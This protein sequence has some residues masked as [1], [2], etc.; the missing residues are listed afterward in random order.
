MKK[1][2]ENFLRKGIW[3]LHLFVPSLVHPYMTEVAFNLATVP[4]SLSMQWYTEVSQILWLLTVYL[5]GFHL[6]INSIESAG[7]LNTFSEALPTGE[8]RW[9][10]PQK[11][12]SFDRAGSFGPRSE[13]VKTCLPSKRGAE[14]KSL[15]GRSSEHSA[16]PNCRS[17]FVLNACCCVKSKVL[18]KW[19][20]VKNESEI[21]GNTHYLCPSGVGQI[22]PEGTSMTSDNNKLA[23]CE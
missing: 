20:R 4:G 6:N 1:Y 3:L 16:V 19:C 2:I 21:G 17:Y 15:Y 12:E 22:S 13:R 23:E 11:K 8:Q 7:C 18:K 9:D 10:F 5:S 14:G